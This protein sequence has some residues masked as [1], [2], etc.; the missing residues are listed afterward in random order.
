MSDN[1]VAFFVFI[2]E[3]FQFDKL[4][5]AVSL[6]QTPYAYNQPPHTITLW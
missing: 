3:P 2:N 5:R 1:S 4:H 6:K